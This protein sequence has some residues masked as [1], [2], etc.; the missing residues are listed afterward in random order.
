[1]C[2]EALGVAEAL[3][4]PS[5]AAPQIQLREAIARLED[6]QAADALQS[7]ATAS[8]AQ[9]P[10]ARL[11]ETVQAQDP[12]VQ[13]LEEQRTRSEEAGTLYTREGAHLLMSLG[14]AKGRVGDLRGALEA[15]ALAK[16]AYVEADCLESAEGIAL[17]SNTGFA[18]IHDDDMPLFRG[19]SALGIKLS[20]SLLTC[21]RGIRI[22]D[23]NHGV[24]SCLYL[25]N[26]AG[27]G[28]GKSRLGACV[29]S[30]MEEA[31]KAIW[32]DLFEAW[33]PE[34]QVPAVLSD[35]KKA[36]TFEGLT[37]R[38]RRT[39]MGKATAS[40][41]KPSPPAPTDRGLVEAYEAAGGDEDTWKQDMGDAARDY[42]EVTYDSTK[43]S[44]SQTFADKFHDQFESMVP[45]A[46]YFVY[47]AMGDD[48]KP[49]GQALVKLIRMADDFTSRGGAWL[50]C[51]HLAASD[52]Y[53]GYWAEKHLLDSEEVIYH[54]CAVPAAQ[55]KSKWGAS[56][57]Q[58]Q[59]HFNKWTLCPPVG[60]L[61]MPWA[62]ETGLQLMREKLKSQKRHHEDQL[63]AQKRRQ[64]TREQLAED[65]RRLTGGTGAEPVLR[66]RGAEASGLPS[67][68]R[69]RDGPDSRVGLPADEGLPARQPSG[70]LAGVLD[71]FDGESFG[72]S[73]VGEQ[74]RGRAEGRGQGL[75]E[76]LPPPMFPPPPAPAGAKRRR[77]D[78]AERQEDAA[79]NRGEGRKRDKRGKMSEDLAAQVLIF[80]KR[81]SREL[82]KQ[83]F[84]PVLAAPLE[85]WEWACSKWG[86]CF[87]KQNTSDAAASGGR[88]SDLKAVRVQAYVRQCLFTRHM[89]STIGERNARE[90]TTMALALDHILTGNLAGAGDVLMQ[91][92]KSLEA[93]LGSKSW[94]MAKHLELA[95]ASN[96][97]IATMEELEAVSRA[98]R[99]DAKLRGNSGASRE[100][101]A[102]ALLRPVILKAREDNPLSD[103]LVLT[104]A[105]P[106]ALRWADELEKRDVGARAHLEARAAKSPSRS[107]SASGARSASQGRSSVGGV[108]DPLDGDRLSNEGSGEETEEQTKTKKRARPSVKRRK[109]ALQWQQA[110][111]QASP[112]DA[113]EKAARVKRSGSEERRAHDKT[114][115]WGALTAAASKG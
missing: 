70:G 114:K 21:L 98:E 11:P 7:E 59:I 8:A 6:R 1:A 67:G 103:G 46:E 38:R 34:P 100:K 81:G 37:R 24:P 96:E 41:P 9:A 40:S 91:R 64:A 93:A 110:Q 5:D 53:Y 14:A 36:E 107:R 56:P 43:F 92:L 102:G 57:G 32:G 78:K 55:C 113:E 88:F 115:K 52:S 26:V 23:E 44:S 54:L 85:G 108:E 48:K 111:T 74:L 82:G 90:V 20:Q 104:P 65:E 69:S 28:A 75:F 99:R 22:G 66:E 42:G 19:P 3:G 2:Q 47:E 73:D 15:F 79:E 101:P 4:V 61:C 80:N 33:V 106:P 45:E 51:A 68:L 62:R 18:Q 105:R 112:S 13:D 83:D 50:R 60:M 89:P 77:G 95:P 35:I 94:Q 49:Q 86:S 97:G 10:E 84:C 71:D 25:G 72:G 63:K 16:A 58:K 31:A 87:V 27:C 30:P 76:G 12:A 17:L 109:R 39:A 29:V